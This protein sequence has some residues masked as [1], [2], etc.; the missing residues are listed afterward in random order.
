[1][2]HPEENN[3]LKKPQ[4]F[5]MRNGHERLESNEYENPVMCNIYQT[6]FEK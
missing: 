2:T 1:V 6:I 3:P 4:I 5:V